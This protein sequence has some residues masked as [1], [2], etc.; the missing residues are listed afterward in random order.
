MIHAWHEMGSGGSWQLDI[1]KNK[2]DWTI[3]HYDHHSGVSKMLVIVPDDYY[4]RV[5]YTKTYNILK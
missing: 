5:N 3:M 1:S 2:T 4:Y